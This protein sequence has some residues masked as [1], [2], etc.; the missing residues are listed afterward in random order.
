MTVTINGKDA[1]K[2]WG[3]VFDT[4]AISAL[5]MPAGMKSYIEN[6]SRLEH[7]KKIITGTDIAKVDSRN[8]TLTFSL[9]A[10]SEEQ[11]FTRLA[12]FRDEIQ[13]T[14]EINIILSVEPNTVYKCIYKSFDTF[15]QYN[16]RLA[17]CSMKVYEP[18]PKDRTLTVYE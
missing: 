10:S 7:G 18:N 15:T 16:N 17:K 14:G 1:H 2:T 12:A 13:A 6:V 4:S 8:I 11:F 3:I 9:C 5:M